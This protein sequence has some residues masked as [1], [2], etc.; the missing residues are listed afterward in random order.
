MPHKI[1]ETCC[2]QRHCNLC[3]KYRKDLERY[4][5]LEEQGRLI[6]LPFK[7]GD[8]IYELQKN[9]K[10]IKQHKIG[11]ILIGAEGI[12]E[13]DFTYDTS[14][15][16]VGFGRSPEECENFGFNF[17][18]FNKTVFLTKGEAEQALKELM[19]SEK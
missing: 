18:N 9:R 7:I 3:D 16:F 4:Q 12:V 5:K 2:K 13:V 14:K 8:N 11:S 6:K 19:E 15:T 17:W 1:D 10:R